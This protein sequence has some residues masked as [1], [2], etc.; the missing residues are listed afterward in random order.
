V[1][2]G[3]FHLG[4]RDRL[5]LLSALEPKPAPSRRQERAGGGFF[6]SLWGR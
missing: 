5:A 4:L 2:T 1:P 6:T 3:E